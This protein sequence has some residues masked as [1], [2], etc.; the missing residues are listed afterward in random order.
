MLSGLRW[1]G[2]QDRIQMTRAAAV[3]GA[4]LPPDER[5][6]LRSVSLLDA[7][8]LPLATQA[9]GLTHEAAAQRLVER[10]IVS[11]NP[12]AVWPF[13]LH[14]LIRSTTRSA[15]NQTD[16]RWST[17]DWQRAAE[18][19]FSALGDQLNSSQAPGRLLLTAALNP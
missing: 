11:E 4:G 14:A 12:Y 7:F 10:P 1:N 8:D 15:D 18:R 5:H 2:V 17:T 16:D 19:A 13:H 9:A 6:V 3:T